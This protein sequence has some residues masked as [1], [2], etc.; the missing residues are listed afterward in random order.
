MASTPDGKGYWL[1][2]SD[3]GIF[4]YGDARA[5]VLPPW[6]SAARSRR[7]RPP[8][9][10]R[11]TRPVPSSGV[12]YAYGDAG[13]YGS[14]VGPDMSVVAIA[15]TSDG[16]GYWLV[17]SNGA[18]FPYGD[19]TPL[20]TTAGMSLAKPVVAAAAVSVMT[21]SGSLTSPTTQPPATTTTTRPPATTT[22]TWPACHDHDDGAADDHDDGA[23]DDHH[24]GSQREA[25]PVVRWQ[26]QRGTRRAR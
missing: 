2:A 23:A 17:T 25:R 1:V 18:V 15:A 26:R 6:R 19:A 7:W 4:N 14:G 10:G 8:R 21:S 22:T 5:T 12:V 3:G 20:G 9:T 13:F 24:D 11:A 16:L